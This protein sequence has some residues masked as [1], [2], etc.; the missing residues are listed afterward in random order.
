MKKIFK[1]SLCLVLL[2][3]VG[4][5]FAACGLCGSKPKVL[6]VNTYDELLTAIEGGCWRD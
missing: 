6:E 4:V 2:I 1:W 3:V 5:A